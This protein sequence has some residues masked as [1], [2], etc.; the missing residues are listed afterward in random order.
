MSNNTTEEDARLKEFGELERLR[1]LAQE[2]RDDW[3]SI[4]H[5]DA[6]DLCT[7]EASTQR[8]HGAVGGLLDGD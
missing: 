3:V 7:R 4:P 6:D 8:L 1:Q 5:F 2:A